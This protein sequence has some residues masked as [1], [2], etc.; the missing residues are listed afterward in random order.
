MIF[1]FKWKKQS[2]DF[3]LF[4]TSLHH[5]SVEAIG[6]HFDSLKKILNAAHL[7][8]WQ[9]PFDFHSDMMR[10]QLRE[11]IGIAG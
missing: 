1:E 11:E 2:A 10:H 8:I 6:E 4:W 5:L 7:S 9:D 3:L